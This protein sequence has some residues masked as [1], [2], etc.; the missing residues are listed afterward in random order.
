MARNRATARAM[1]RK[2]VAA[3]S[4]ICDLRHWTDMLNR[5]Y[6]LLS[7]QGCES[8]RLGWVDDFHN[9]PSEIAAKKTP[10]NQSGRL[11]TGRVK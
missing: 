10:R 1:K 9:G 6:E 2:T 4:V 7:N 8:M 3:A 5:A 11:R